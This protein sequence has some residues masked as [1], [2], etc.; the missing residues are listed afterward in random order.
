MGWTRA[1]RRRTMHWKHRGLT[2]IGMLLLAIPGVVKV[3]T[4][5]V[6]AQVAQI[7]TT[8]VTDTVFLADGTTATGTVIV[9]WQAFTTPLGQS[10]PAGTTSATIGS[11][12]GLSL[13]LVPNAGGTPMG[14][15]YTAVYHLDDGTV[16]REFWVVPVSQTPVLVSAIKSTVLPT[17]VAMQPVSKSYVDTAIATA[18]SG[19]PLDSSSPFVLI[20]GSTMTGPLVL[21]GDPTAANQAAAKHS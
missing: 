1:M 12:G 9:T 7:A 11:G 18:I 4:L 8:Q 20:T 21:P 13:Q 16:S 14:N 2:L 10:V 6:S 3:M 19:H 17:S 15:Y 5:P